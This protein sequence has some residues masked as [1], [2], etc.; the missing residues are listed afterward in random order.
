MSNPELE[1]KVRNAF[2]RLRLS[3]TIR[4]GAGAL[5]EIEDLINEEQATVLAAVKQCGCGG[6]VEPREGGTVEVSQAGGDG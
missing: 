5:R 4:V 1:R 3:M 6:A 2:E